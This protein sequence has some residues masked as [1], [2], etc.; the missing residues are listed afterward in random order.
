DVLFLIHNVRRE[1]RVPGCYFMDQAAIWQRLGLSR[2]TICRMVKRLEQLGLVTRQRYSGDHRRISVSLTDEGIRRIR[3]ALDVVFNGR[4]MV[5]AYESL[6][7]ERKWSR[8]TRP[9]LE[10]RLAMLFETIF[11][12]ARLFEDSSKP[13]YRFRFEIDR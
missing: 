11:T 10:F 12:V 4:A 2:A 6:W 8:R 3:E 5:R 13:L 1:M 9:K 7:G